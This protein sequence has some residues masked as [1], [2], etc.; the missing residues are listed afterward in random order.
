M[1][2]NSKYFTL[3]FGILLPSSIVFLL[4]IYAGYT[5]IHLETQKSKLEIVALHFMF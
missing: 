2:F 1:I 4:L 3:D 5:H